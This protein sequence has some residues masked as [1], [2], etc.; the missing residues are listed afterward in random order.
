MEASVRFFVFAFGQLT[1]PIW[2]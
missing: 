1:A 2:G